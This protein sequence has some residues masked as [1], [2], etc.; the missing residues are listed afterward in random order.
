MEMVLKTCDNESVRGVLVLADIA[1]Q[2]TVT[3][4]S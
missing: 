1:A 3:Q 4:N 2:A